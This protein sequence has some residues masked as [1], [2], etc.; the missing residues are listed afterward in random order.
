M[1]DE[2]DKPTLTRKPL[3]LKRTVEAGQVQ[4]QFSHGRRNTVVVEVKR[5][6]VLG[7]PGEA[8]PV[9][10]EEVEAAPAPAP[11]P[12]PAP[13]PAPKPAAPRVS[14]NDSLMS[15][16]E[17]Q[18]QLLREAEEARMSAQE[19]NRRRDEAARA[20][21]AEEE[22]AR[23]E[24]KVEQATAKA[25]EPAPAAPA[26]EA[27][28]AA[29]AA[30]APVA[31]A[32]P[33]SEAA[34]TPAPRATTS[35][36]PAPRR[37]TPVAAP[38]RPEPK[39][40]EPKATR[41]G[42][43]RR[44]SGKL[45]VTRALNEDE[46][47]RARSLA[48]LKRAREKE[49]RSHTASSGPREKQIREVTVPE[50][51]TVQ[52]L[53]NRMAEKTSDLVKALFKMG[54]PSASTDTIDQDT[55]ELLVTEFGH[56]IIRVSEGDIDIRHDEDVDDAEHLKPRA[57]V[58]TIMGHVDHGKTSLLDALRGANVQ[59]G[60][61]GGIT[62]HIGAY[63]VK[64]PD[65]SLVTF[66]DTP[67]HEA[68]TEMRQRGANVTDI[69]I[70]VVA[71]DDGLK[72]QSIE[73]INHAKAANV[74]IIVAI[75]KVDKEGAN[76]QRVRERLL[77]HE[78]VVEE[79]GGDVQNVEVSALKKTG[80][81][82]LLDA[83]AVQAEIM[84]LKANP[85]RAAE[86]TV[87]EAKLDKGRGPVAT[88]LVRRGT[89]KVGDIFVCGAESGRVRALIDDQGKQIKSATPS[90][91]VEVLGLGGVPMAGDT[92]TVVEN[93]ARAREVA[94]YRQ[95]QATRKRTVQAPVSLEGMFEALAD[96][97]NVI[98][99]PVIIKGDVQGSVEAI[100]NALNKLSTDEIRV[101]VLQSGAGAITESDVTLAAATKAPIIG[102]NVRPNAKARDIA[103]REKV[104]FMYHDVIYHLTDEIR[105]EMAGELGPER[106]ET[107][108][109]RAEVKDVFPAG[110]RDKAAGLLV[111][112]GSIRKGLHARLTRDDVI[113][114]ATTISSL[115]RFK[116]DV[117]EVRAGLECGVVLADTNDIKA[118]DHLEVFEVELRERTL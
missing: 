65:G 14:E 61:A 97:A 85:D 92:L 53:A 24:A 96:K 36:A 13:A 16:Q 45:T 49:K 73:A 50:S 8:A 42:D 30:E 70:L 116:D 31:A 58:V 105:K 88:I 37:F 54:V 48:A 46:G 35:A 115:R 66:L 6:R 75:N 84:E 21:A 40:P 23:A 95:E 110:K 78:L 90:M 71:A 101:R 62:Q 17:R 11:T 87:V 102:F 93:E 94:T 63:Q 27:P 7:R 83:I 12:A 117:A 82:K 59:A 89:L 38:Q 15:R 41:G 118:G 1:S 26:A 51:I 64:T 32:A 28:A 67:G 47:A 2:Q 104:R 113:V 57:P 107:V 60:E 76:P 9:E 74:P 103:K 5:R 77:E 86:G 99:F 114:S 29:P 39:R 44:Q 100:V 33:Q 34:P 81:D 91:P 25:V 3:G 43:S 69:V 72:P 68:F 52:D 18:A 108:V 20:R 4:Q 111:L 98:Q 22:K 55:A 109:G 112:E 19:D 10:A 106:I 79:M 56:E 80:L